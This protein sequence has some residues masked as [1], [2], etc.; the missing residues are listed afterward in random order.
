MKKIDVSQPRRDYYNDECGLSTCPECGSQ[1]IEE[2]CTILLCAKSDSDE[3][4]FATNLSGS[5]FCS[6]CP[7]VVFDVEKVGQAAKFGI[8]GDKNLEYF[9]SGI[10]DLESIPEDKKHL[11]IGCEENPIPLI[12]F[13]PDLN[14]QAIIAD[15]KSGRNEPCSCGSGK[16][17]KKCCGK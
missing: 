17:Y 1:L 6:Q 7:V 14:A 5:H 12:K 11:E 13:L 10:I 2:N 15:T 8:R 4:K 3:G 16:K 9:I